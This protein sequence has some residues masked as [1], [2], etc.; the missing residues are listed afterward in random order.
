MIPENSCDR[1]G[2]MKDSGKETFTINF[3]I[4]AFYIFYYIFEPW[5][6]IKYSKKKNVSAYV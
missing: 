5:K 4:L 1:T 6:Y 2:Q 3:N